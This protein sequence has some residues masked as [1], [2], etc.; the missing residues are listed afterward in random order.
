VFV[1]SV[2]GYARVSTIDQASDG[3]SLDA[4]RSR[5][6]AW[7]EATGAELQQVV[8]DAG[9]SG[10]KPFAEREGGAQIA[11][12]L[13]ARKPGVDAVVIVALDRLGRDAGECLTLLRKFSRGNVGLVSI[14]DRLDLSTPHGRAMAGVGAVFGQLERELV[15]QRTA[16]AMGELRKQRRVYSP[17][18]FGWLAVEGSLVPCES[19]QRVLARLRLMRSQGMGYHGIALRLN[20]DGVPAKRSNR[21]HAPTVS[22]VLATSERLDAAA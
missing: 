14:T 6:E 2:I 5:I 3:V 17:V 19:E 13:D 4:Q 21:W 20:R 16:A 7:S 10:S 9:V 18:P 1:I 8:V 15:G 22:S 12:L 11:A